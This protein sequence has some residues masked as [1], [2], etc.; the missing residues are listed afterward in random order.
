MNV[1]N[2]LVFGLDKPYQ[3]SLVYDCKAVAYTSCLGKLLALT[4]NSKLGC[5]DVPGK[6]T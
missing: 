3:S 2:K 1:R 6:Y 4:T 5:K